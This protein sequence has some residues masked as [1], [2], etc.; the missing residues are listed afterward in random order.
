MRLVRGSTGFMTTRLTSATLRTVALAAVAAI[1]AAGSSGCRH[2]AGAYNATLIRAQE[3]HDLARIRHDTRDELA[4]QREEARRVAA[5][6]EVE[7]AR[8]AAERQQ[9]EAE[10]CQANQE[11]LQRQVRANVR[12]V[13]ESKV[14]FDVEHGLEVGELEVDVEELQEL[15]KKRQEEIRRPPEPIRRPPCAC[16]DQPCGCEPGLIRRLCP[17]CRHKPCEAERDCG[18]PEALA[19]I[20]QEGLRRPLKPA[21]I[22]LKLPV[23]L[24][25]GIQQPEME[26]ARIRKQPILQEQIRRPCPHPCDD[27]SHCRPP[28]TQAAPAGTRA[29]VPGS[30]FRGPSSSGA[31]ELIDEELPPQGQE[32]VGPPPVPESEARRAIR[33]AHGFGIHPVGYEPSLP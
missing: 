29:E 5:R 15:L 12:D 24:S 23:R 13:L 22:P 17:H 31:D 26:A 7:A 2:F 20:E 16:C 18:G 8:I 9:L 11:A 1:A 33:A 25:F 14:A 6:Q 19:R 27:P 30:E 4:A 3:W 28:C 10:F 21:E 32:N